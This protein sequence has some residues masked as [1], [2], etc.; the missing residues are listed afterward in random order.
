M[1]NAA[2]IRA[3]IWDLG[4]VL[5]RTHDRT[6][7]ERWEQ[8]LGLAPRE[9]EEIVFGCEMSRQAFVGRA[10]VEDIWQAVA[11]Q[12]GVPE[13]D[14][15]QLEQD[16]WSG[17]QIEHGLVEFIRQ[18]RPAYKTG[19]IS[20]AWNP[21]RSLMEE[22]K[23]ADAFDHLTISA[24]IGIAKPDPRI[25]THSLEALR[26]MPQQAI[27]VDDFKENIAAARQFGLHAVHF[28]DPEQA[29]AEVEGLLSRAP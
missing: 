11:D 26:V 23:I 24:E 18:L 9:L 27:F 25:Y 16:F 10:E 13:K 19:L 28:K 4:G 15:V 8:K 2:S 6:G 3:V 1:K 7:R 17:D 14:R 21:L 22:W 12:L 29:I 5:L 20:N